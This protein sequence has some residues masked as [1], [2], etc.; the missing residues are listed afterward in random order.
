[1]Y[2]DKITTELVALDRAPK[3]DDIPKRFENKTQVVLVVE[4]TEQPQTVVLVFPVGIVQ[5]LQAFQLTLPNLVPTYASNNRELKTHKTIHVYPTERRLVRH[6]TDGLA[7]PYLRELCCPTVAIQRLISLC[8]VT[9]PPYVNCYPS[10]CG[11]SDGLEWSI[12]LWS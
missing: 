10:L 2:D 12:S 4:V 11:W 5:L 3:I 6:W 9:G 1:M 8:G 7:P